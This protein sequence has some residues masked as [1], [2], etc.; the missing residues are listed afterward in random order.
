[1][2]ISAHDTFLCFR[3]DNHQRATDALRPDTPA[4]PRLEDLGLA[5]GRLGRTVWDFRDGMG[6][7]EFGHAH[8]QWEA[9]LRICTAAARTCATMYDIFEQNLVNCKPL[10]SIPGIMPNLTRYVR[11]KNTPEIL[12]LSYLTYFPL[13][14]STS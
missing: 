6:C 7:L 10:N 13:P 9:G 14:L 5:F 4:E 1:V 12:P 11:L 2:D 3:S 8:E